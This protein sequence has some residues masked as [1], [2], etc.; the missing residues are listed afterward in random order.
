MVASYDLSKSAESVFQDFDKMRKILPADVLTGDDASKK[1]VI[2]RMTRGSTS[3][4]HILAHGDPG[5]KKKVVR[6]FFFFF[7]FQQGTT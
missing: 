4:T 7:F 1:E 5:G 2:E 3:L 6:K